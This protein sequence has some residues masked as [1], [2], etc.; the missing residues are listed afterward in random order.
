MF[1]LLEGL[2]CHL[3]E[4]SPEMSQLQASS[5]KVNLGK[6]EDSNS[7]SDR[8][9]M[10]DNGV[11]VHWYNHFKSIPPAFSV[12]LAHEFFDALPIHKFKVSLECD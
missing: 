10:T 2:S 3:V 5:L 8:K 4:I 11:P 9:G 1:N 6:C 12:I 7:Q